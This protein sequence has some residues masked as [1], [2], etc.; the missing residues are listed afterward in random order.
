MWL[1][2]SMNTPLFNM[3]SSRCAILAFCAGVV[4]S[5]ITCSLC[6]QCNTLKCELFRV[7]T[8]VLD[9]VPYIS[10]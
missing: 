7:H 2:V 4:A 1:V 6:Y 3:P 10:A 9:L 5:N 8:G